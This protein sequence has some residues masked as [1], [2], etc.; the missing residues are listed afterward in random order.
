MMHGRA[1]S[2][3]ARAIRLAA[4]VLAAAAASRGADAPPL[5]CQDNAAH[6]YWKAAAL[7]QEPMT[8]GEFDIAAF[9]EKDLPMLAPRVLFLRMDAFRWLLN[10]RPMLNALADA[11]RRTTCDFLVRSGDS[12]RLDLSHLPRLKAVTLRALAVGR[13]YQYAD[14]AEG[15]ALL[16]TLLLRMVESLDRD[17]SLGSC[18]AAAD[19]LQLVLSD[20]EAFLGRTPRATAAVILS[21]YFITAPSRL[22]H[23]GDA[24]RDEARR[25]GDFLLADAS[26]PEQRLATLYGTARSRPGVDRLVTL[27]PKRK[28]ERMKQWVAGYRRHMLALAEA[29]DQPFQ[30]ALSAIQRLDAQKAAMEK[31]PPKEGA[32]PLIPLLVPTMAGAYQKFVLAEAQYDMASILCPAALYRAETGAWP[33]DLE[34]LSRFA[35]RV[36]PKDP[37]SGE[38]YH[39]RLSR[40][41]PMLT[42]RVPKTLANRPGMIYSLEPES[43]AKTENDR[44]SRYIRVM[45]DRKTDDVNTPVRP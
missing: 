22:L 5:P 4:A 32:N 40:G 36:F 43:R 3:P 14:N 18:L 27:D 20:L 17:V 16:E 25:Y 2:R 8:R 15:A 31:K 42:T 13:A 29:V 30:D 34:A 26:R 10:E 37:F 11:S 9:T 1:N 39:Y 23:P 28:Q 35:N 33:P 6:F 38:E 44:V 19:I 45:Q 24:L 12:P 21:R 41:S 7:M